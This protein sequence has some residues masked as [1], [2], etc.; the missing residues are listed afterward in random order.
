MVNDTVIFALTSSVDL[1]KKVCKD[2]DVPL[3]KIKVEH[4]ADG[5]ILVTPQESVRGRSVFI[6]QSTCNPVTERLMEVLVCIDAC[7]RASAREINVIMPYYGYARQDR[8]TK[9]RQPITAKLVADL[10]QKAGAHRVVVF[11]LHAAQIQGFFNIPIDDITA[12]PMIGQYFHQKFRGRDD[13]VVVSPDHGG[14]T[15]ARRL[16]DILDAS[17]AIIDKRRPKPNMVEAQNVIG[18][19]DGKTCIVIDDICDTAGSLTA[20]CEILKKHGASEIYCAITHGVF[21]RDAVTKIQNS[22]IREMIITD[23][24]PLSEENKAKTDKIKVLYVADMIATAIDSILNH[25]P[26]SRVYEMYKD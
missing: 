24:I 4:F 23:T 9:P 17:I 19:V 21:S 6:V 7:K 18:N 1:A 8:T 12:V 20:G 26:V 10:I 13:L 3:G 15:R 25:M 22:P 2:L 11:D 14:V 5:E 16:A